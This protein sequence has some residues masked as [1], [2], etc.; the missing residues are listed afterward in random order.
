[1]GLLGFLK[2]RDILGHRFNINYKGKDSYTTSIGTLFSIVIDLMAL[3]KC[4]SSFICL[5]EMTDPMIQS[6]RRAMYPAEI[7]DY[8]VQNLQDN[9]FSLGLITIDKSGNK[10]HLPERIGRFV[11]KI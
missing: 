8:G 2:G 4:V 1:M 9:F 11:A 3:I 6:Y 7:E 5:I 10:V